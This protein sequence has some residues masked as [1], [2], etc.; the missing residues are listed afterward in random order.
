MWFTIREPLTI[1]AERRGR[2]ESA[3]RCRPCCKH[4][5]VPLAMLTLLC[6]M[7]GVFILAAFMPNY[8]IDYLKLTNVQMGYVT[9]A[10]GFG[11]FLGQLGIPALSD[12]IGRRLSAVI[13]FAIAAVFLYLFAKTDASS[14]PVL[15]ALLFV[16]ALFNFGALAVIAGPIAAE[17]APLGLIASVSGL[18]IGVGE[19][20]GGGIAPGIAG[21]IAANSG[22]Q[23]RA[24]FRARRARRR[25][26][27]QLL[28]ARDGAATR[29]GFHVGRG[30]ETSTGWKK[31]IR[32]V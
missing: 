23:Q 6:A 8:L 24:V 20:F 16:A 13:S 5:N 15:F 32:K 25:I 3:R 17:A 22:I 26:P 9:S 30:F 21:S 4:R 10:I 1:T 18:V 7:S 27:D 2:A 12:F 29:P 19:I 11:G 28:P 14:L 31:R